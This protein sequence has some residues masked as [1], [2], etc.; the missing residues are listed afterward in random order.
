MKVKV[1]LELDKRQVNEIAINAI[2]RMMNNAIENARYVM[3]HAPRNGYDAERASINEVDF[4]E[5]KPTIRLVWTRVQD[6]LYRLNAGL[7]TQEEED[8]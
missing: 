8:V 2:E 1:V 6:A 4:E 3:A 5:L 7:P